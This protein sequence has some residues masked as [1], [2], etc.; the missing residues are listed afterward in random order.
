MPSNSYKNKFHDN[1]YPYVKNRLLDDGRKASD[2]TVNTAI[3]D[4]FYLERKRGDTDFLDWFKDEE[5]LKEAKEAI[6]DLLIKANRQ[7]SNFEYDLKWYCRLLDYFYDYY[8]NNGKALH[9]APKNE[10]MF[11]SKKSFTALICERCGGALDKTGEYW[12]CKNCG[13]NY[14][15]D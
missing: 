8:I 11:K 12:T 3:S 9:N 10:N 1:L 13:T 15:R 14:I 5:K 6:K 4:M 7:S 2:S